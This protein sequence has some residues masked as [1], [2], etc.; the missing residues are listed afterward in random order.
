[1]GRD[2]PE[3]KAALWRAIFAA[4]PKT[5]PP[6][7]AKSYAAS[8]ASLELMVRVA[9]FV[10]RLVGEN[11]T[12]IVV[13]FDTVTVPTGEVVIKN[14]PESAPDIAALVITKSLVPVFWIVKVRLTIAEFAIAEP[15][16]V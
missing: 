6:L 11:A 1:M 3:L 12:T 15:K 8:S 9:F 13:E 10:P 4:G 16:F 14:R 7:N 2:V 5:P